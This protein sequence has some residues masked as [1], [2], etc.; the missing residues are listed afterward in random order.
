MEK[1]WDIVK[2]VAGA[3]VIV[4][5]IQGGWSLAKELGKKELQ[6]ELEGTP[7]IMNGEPGKPVVIQCNGKKWY[8][9]LEEVEN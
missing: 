1:T 2:T 5:A 3:F 9:K 8:M 7:T 6:K 4:Y